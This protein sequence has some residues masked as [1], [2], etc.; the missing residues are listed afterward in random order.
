MK[1]QNTT[2]IFTKMLPNKLRLFKLYRNMKFHL[3]RTIVI[4]A[5]AQN[6]MFT[7]ILN[8]KC[9]ENIKQ[10]V[11]INLMQSLTT[12]NFHDV[13]ISSICSLLDRTKSIL[14]EIPSR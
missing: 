9:N 10:T 6:L 5:G 2:Y 14:Y 13:I 11:Q 4:I 3:E 1:K 7:L 12:D 8:A